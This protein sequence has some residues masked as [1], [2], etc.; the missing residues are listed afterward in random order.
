MRWI[1]AAAVLLVV[2]VASLALNVYQYSSPRS[3]TVIRTTTFT[4]ATTQLST[5]TSIQT[6]TAVTQTS[7]TVTD[8][9]TESETSTTT[10]TVASTT[11]PW[12]GLTYLGA[13]PGCAVSTDPPTAWYPVPCF[14]Y[15]G[16]HLFNCA[17]AANTSQGCTQRIN[18]TGTSNQSFA[19]TV[20]YPY[21][22]YTGPAWQN[23]KY[24]VPS[25]P[26]PPGPQGPYYAYCISVNSTSFLITEPA[27]PPV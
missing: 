17:A 19:V 2:A 11:V 13:V 5:T 12:Y 4:T 3:V 21:V 15:S 22:N 8:T 1:A 24:T 26:N 10:E 16:P 18:I 14:G 23:C 27:P 6:Q 25:V 20:W 9:T 7:Y